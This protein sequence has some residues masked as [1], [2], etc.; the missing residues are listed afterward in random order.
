M[1]VYTGGLFDA[2]Y[3]HSS[4]L[5]YHCSLCSFALLSL[6]AHFFFLV[7]AITGDMLDEASLVA[8]I[9]YFGIVVIGLIFAFH[10]VALDVKQR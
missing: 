2:D 10:Y 6:P 3:L 9:N 8:F 7:I 5:S 1:S 4:Y